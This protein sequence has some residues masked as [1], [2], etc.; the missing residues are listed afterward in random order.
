MHGFRWIVLV[1]FVLFLSSNIIVAQKFR[2]PIWPDD[3]KQKTLLNNNSKLGSF[4]ALNANY[5][6]AIDATWIYIGAEAGITI[7]DYFLLGI[8]GYGLVSSNTIENANVAKSD[9]LNVY[10]GYGGVLLGAKIAPKKVFHVNIPLFLGIG[11]LEISD[12]NYF[13]QGDPKFTL[14][15]SQYFVME[16][17]VE[18]E[19]NITQKFKLGFAG[20]YRFISGT[21]LSFFEDKDLKTATYQMSLKFGSN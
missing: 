5:S 14:E 4:G 17:R 18:A 11:N 10:G 8:A 9:Q 12:N 20:G 7:N 3:D 6:R 19:L 1:I 2:H 15:R 16:P 13:P 21:N